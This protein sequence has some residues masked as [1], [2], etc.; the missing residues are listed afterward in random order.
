[1]RPATSTLTQLEHLPNI[2][3]SI[4]ADLRL[5]GITRPT[6]LRRRNPYALYDRLCRLTKTRHDP[7]LL[8]TFIAA[9]RFMNGDPPHPWWHYTKERKATLEKKAARA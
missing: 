2:G 1:M 7:C 3:P 6:Q 9:T 8:D 4:A 5:L